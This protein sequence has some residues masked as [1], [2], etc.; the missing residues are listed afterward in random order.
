MTAANIPKNPHHLRRRGKNGIWWFR[1][2]SPLLKKEINVSLHTSDKKTAIA[3]RNEFILTVMEGAAKKKLS[4]I[5][6]AHCMSS[7]SASRD[8][9]NRIAPGYLEEQQRVKSKKLSEMRELFLEQRI[10]VKKIKVATFTGYKVALEH[11]EAIIGD[12]HVDEIQP[13][14]IERYISEAHKN[15]YAKRV[16]SDL[17]QRTIANRFR[18]I[19][20][21]FDWMRKMRHI[22]EN[23]TADVDCPTYEENSTETPPLELVD[24]L[25]SIP[26]PEGGPLSRETW[27]VF[28]YVLRYTGARI[29][30]A[31]SLESKDIITIDSIPVL[32]MIAEKSQRRKNNPLKDGRKKVPIHPNLMVLLEKLARDRTG[33]LFPDI[34]EI[35]E[36]HGDL[37]EIRYGHLFRG[38][39]VKR[40]K[41]IWPKMKIH[42]WRSYVIGYLTNEAGVHEALAE[43]I[44]GHSRK[45]INRKY[46][47]IARV[48]IL[49]E[50]ICK[51]P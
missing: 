17:S 20:T 13:L 37:C 38:W 45:T 21:F 24:K 11:L 2:K 28:P 34:G 46:A 42:A 18:S 49:Y 31:A 50:A 5:L 43:D 40:A 39:W 30:E 27:H 36:R 26:Y 1:F 25:C 8:A 35:K 22:K 41:E 7:D 33:R 12:R 23:P 44:V 51:L 3:K 47:G 4:I 15:Q 16:T 9:V 19:S 14:D 48:P 10:K 29:G 6:L 32:N